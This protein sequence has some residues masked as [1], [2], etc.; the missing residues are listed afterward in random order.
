MPSA[1]VPR[2]LRLVNAL[3]LLFVL[4]GAGLHLWSWFGMRRLESYVP[5]ED[6]PPFSGLARFEHYWELSRVGNWLVFTGVGVAVVAAIAAV[7]VRRR[8]A[9]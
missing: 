5:P 8:R 2:S 7:V 3:A 4:A 1:P 9:G 6:A